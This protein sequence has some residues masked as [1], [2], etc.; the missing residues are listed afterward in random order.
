M[1]SKFIGI[2]VSI[3]AGC[4]RHNT[5]DFFIIQI[6]DPDEMQGATQ[7][8]TTIFVGV[9]EKFRHFEGND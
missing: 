1:K 4:Q 7:P 3:S 2:W 5:R 8:F 9:G 6:F